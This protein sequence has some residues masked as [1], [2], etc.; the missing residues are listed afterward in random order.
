MTYCVA[1]KVD[2]GIVCL[3]DTRTNAGLDNISK[4][5]KLF[6]WSK[7]G[8]RAVTMM[9]AGNLAITQAVMNL[10]Q[11]N[12]DKPTDGIETVYTAPTMFRLAEI[13]GDAMRI[14]QTR[15]GPGLIARGEDTAASIIVAGQRA[16]GPLRIFLVYAAGNFIEATSDTPY[17]QIGEH[18]YGKPIIDR[19][20]RADMLLQDV[21]KLALLSMDST[22]RS[23]LSVGMPLDMTVLP[24]DQYAFSKERRIDQSDADY[25]AISSQWSDYLSR[26]FNDIPYED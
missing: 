15:Y 19:V 11:E 25:Q 16:G 9:T 17:F 23:N 3:A 24:V 18:K 1:I 14:V 10:L 22:L 20:T 5:K 26:A 12:I 8:E 21:Q 7:Q 6:T 2:A 4:F 13:V